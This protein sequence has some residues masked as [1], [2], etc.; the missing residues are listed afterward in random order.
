MNNFG[1]RFGDRIRKKNRKTAITDRVVESE[2][3]NRLHEDEKIN[4][5][6]EI[7][8]VREPGERERERENE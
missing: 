6:E 3:D 2:K 4:D 5:R 1:E 8:V 7:G